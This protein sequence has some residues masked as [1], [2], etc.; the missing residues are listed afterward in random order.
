VVTEADSLPPPADR[1]QT[2]EEKQADDREIQRLLEAT[3]PEKMED[4]QGVYGYRIGMYLV[5]ADINMPP[6]ERR[7][8]LQQTRG[9]IQEL[10]SVPSGRRMLWRLASAKYPTTLYQTMPRQLVPPGRDPASGFATYTNHRMYRNNDNPHGLATAIHMADLSFP[11]SNLEWVR[12]SGHEASAFLYHEMMHMLHYQEWFETEILSGGTIDSGWQSSD[13]MEYHAVGLGPFEGG[14]ENQYR[15]EMGFTHRN[16]YDPYGI[17][18][19]SDGNIELSGPPHSIYIP[20]PEEFEERR[21]RQGPGNVNF[22]WPPEGPG[23][24]G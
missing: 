13:V 19:D 10:A 4:S 1:A 14:G 21:N 23:P 24:I 9:W 17:D 20:T 6:Q 8:W 22:P 3:P 16:T 2:Q 5:Q 11:D 18:L 12:N 7:R 15:A